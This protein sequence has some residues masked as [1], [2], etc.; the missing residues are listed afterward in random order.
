MPERGD[1]RAAGLTSLSLGFLDFDQ[2]QDHS[3][4]FLENAQAAL[5]LPESSSAPPPCST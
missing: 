5:H 2:A 4:I 3:H 1:A